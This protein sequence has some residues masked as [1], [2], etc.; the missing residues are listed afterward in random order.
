MVTDTLVSIG[1]IAGVFGTKGEFKVDSLTDYDDRFDVGNEIY[2]GA[3]KVEIIRSRK[4]NPR[5]FILGLSSINDRSEAMGIPSGTLLGIPENQLKELP[6][7]EH[8]RFQ[9]IGFEVR[10]FDKTR[11]GYVSEIIETGAN[12][13]FVVTT[14]ENS[15]LLVPNTPEMVKIDAE[16][17]LIFVNT[18]E[19]I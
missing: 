11:I 12:D 7:G 4:I 1:I 5:R 15:E 3:E 14:T 16:N 6:D 8:Y 9:L 2:L 18:I 10:S 17:K 13:V 19:E